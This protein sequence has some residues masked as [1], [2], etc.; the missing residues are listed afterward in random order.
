MPDIN[1]Y[2]PQGIQAQLDLLYLYNPDAANKLMEELQQALEEIREIGTVFVY[3]GTVPTEADLPKDAKPGDVYDVLDT[4]NNYVWNGE[5]WDRLSGKVASDAKDIS[6]DNT[7]MVS[8]TSDNVQGGIQD[9]DNGL[10]TL[11]VGQETL[12]GWGSVLTTTVDLG[13]AGDRT[14]VVLDELKAMPNLDGRPSYRL[15]GATVY[16]PNG[17]QGIIDKIDEAQGTADITAVAEAGGS[18]EGIEFTTELKA[19]PVD[20][21]Q[22]WICSFVNFGELA[23][24][25]YDWYMWSL[26]LPSYYESTDDGGSSLA[27]VLTRKMRHIVINVSNGIPSATGFIWQ[28]AQA[29]GNITGGQEGFFGE[30]KVRNTAPYDVCF[31]L[32]GSD[33]A[34]EAAMYTQINKEIVNIAFSDLINRETKAHIKL[35]SANIQQES[36]ED[37]Y[38][39]TYKPSAWDLYYVR[40]QPVVSINMPNTY[41]E[42]NLG[43]ASYATGT[44]TTYGCRTP[45]YEN[46]TGREYYSTITVFE[47][48]TDGTTVALG[49]LTFNM[50]FEHATYQTPQTERE[51][52]VASL[53]KTGV[54]ADKEIT[55]VATADDPTNIKIKINEYEPIW[56]S[57]VDNYEAERRNAIWMNSTNAT[58][59]FNGGFGITGWTESVFEEA[60]NVSHEYPIMAQGG[61][62]GSSDYNELSNKPKIDGVTISGN[63]TALDYGLATAT[64]FVQINERVS[65]VEGDVDNLLNNPATKV[66]IRRL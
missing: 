22:A 4:D 40:R 38:D 60:P 39:G 18:S 25:V 50:R 36:P 13:K 26:G 31:Y 2:P 65:E 17:V 61:G 32:N 45:Q 9:L 34:S 41:N 14:T 53:K 56:T 49:S 8:V 55:F 37:W 24:G 62:G 48:K 27:S 19:N 23:D 54:Y 64:D 47:N 59:G 10:K 57:E 42:T 30:I 29:S 28:D 7:G 21:N 1:N 63:K 6:L 5:K 66:I 44:R 16:G 43:L 12:S 46:E 11:A 33:S 58:Y 15:P 20:Y 52:Y 51:M 3:R 35:K